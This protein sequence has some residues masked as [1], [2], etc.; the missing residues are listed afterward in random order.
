MYNNNFITRNWLNWYNV[1]KSKDIPGWNKE[2]CCELQSYQ[3]GYT[4]GF[5][6]LF[7]IC[8]SYQ[9]RPLRIRSELYPKNFSYWHL[10]LR[11]CNKYHTVTCKGIID[12]SM[13]VINDIVN[14][15]RNWDNKFCDDGIQKLYCKCIDNNRLFSQF[16]ILC[17]LCTYVRYILV[18][19]YYSIGVAWNQI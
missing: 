2:M 3:E 17:S 5:H 19:A 14:L 9:T 12:M 1:V 18:H 7:L 16:K 6:K 10:K 11:T 8:G 13:K 15:I 4:R